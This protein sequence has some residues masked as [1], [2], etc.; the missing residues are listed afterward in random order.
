M[1]QKVLQKTW[2][3]RSVN[4]I[5]QRWTSKRAWRL[6]ISEFNIFEI[7]FAIALELCIAFFCAI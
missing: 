7:I 2:N 4:W 6:V 5:A 1:K 3:L